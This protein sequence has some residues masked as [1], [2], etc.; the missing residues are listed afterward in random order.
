MKTHWGTHEAHGEWEQNKDITY[1]DIT[2][3]QGVLWD[4]LE[5]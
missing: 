3:H 4:E 5:T 2:E 1:P